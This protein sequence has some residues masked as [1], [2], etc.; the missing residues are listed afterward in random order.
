MNFIKRIHRNLQSWSIDFFNLVNFSKK[1]QLFHIFA[2]IT[3]SHQLSIC[4]RMLMWIMKHLYINVHSHKK[5]S[6]NSVIPVKIHVYRPT[7][8][9]SVH[10]KMV[11][12]FSNL[13]YRIKQ[14][15]WNGESWKLGHFT[16]SHSITE[17][18]EKFIKTKANTSSSPNFIA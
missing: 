13:K 9:F 14:I 17:C 11:V 2:L 16:E 10:K 4:V 7:W 6:T 1:K 8:L 3:F 5:S 12:A 15:L 18:Q